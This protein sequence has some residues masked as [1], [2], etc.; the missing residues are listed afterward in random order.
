MKRHDYTY[1][2][3]GG[4]LNFSLGLVVGGGMGAWVCWGPIDTRW[5]FIALTAT[6]ALIVATCC[7][8]WGNAAWEKVSGVLS[9][10]ADIW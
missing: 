5:L 4:W 10:M 7:G 1:G 2:S 3:L 8:L 9:V 6:I